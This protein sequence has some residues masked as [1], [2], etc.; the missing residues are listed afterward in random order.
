MEAFLL[1][2]MSTEPSH[3]PSRAL[4]SVATT[5]RLPHSTASFPFMHR[6]ALTVWRPVTLIKK[7]Q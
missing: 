2:T 3:E 1:R 4:V 6:Y 5:V 7:T